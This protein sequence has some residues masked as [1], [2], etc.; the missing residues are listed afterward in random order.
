MKK[1]CRGIL[2]CGVL[3]LAIGLAGCGALP[4]LEAILIDF[5]L[6]PYVTNTFTFS[7]G[8]IA[9]DPNGVVTFKWNFGDGSMAQGQVVSYSYK[10]GGTYTVTLTVVTTDSSGNQR[11]LNFF[12]TVS[13]ISQIAFIEEDSF[14]DDQ[15]YIINADGTGLFQVT[16]TADLGVTDS[17]ELDMNGFGQI[18]YSCELPSPPPGADDDQICAVN[19][20]GTDNRVL[21]SRPHRADNPDIN[22]LGHIVYICEDGAGDP[23]LCT[24]DIN[25]GSRKILTSGVAEFD[26][27]INNLGQI[28]YT[29][30]DPS[31]F[32]PQVCVIDFDGSDQNQLTNN[33]IGFFDVE[34]NDLGV[35]TFE[36][37]DSGFDL[38]ICSIDYNGGSVSQITDSDCCTDFYNP[39]M[40]QF[41]KVAFGCDFFGVPPPPSAGSAPFQ[42]CVINSDGSGFRVTPDNVF[43]TDDHEY[44]GDKIA[45][46]CSDDFFFTVDLCVYNDS[47]TFFN[48]LIDDTIDLED[49]AIR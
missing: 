49:I 1:S 14:G 33:S 46:Y 36:C 37:L 34:I 25:G 20:D 42:R 10:A 17:D 22:D 21:T 7:A 12:T 2:S 11:H 35:V 38:E 43:D 32:T 27:E 39:E 30:I 28:A 48:K 18:V 6:G 4:G 29:C 31:F 45:S 13:V 3:L 8:A 40:N 41:G 47:A 19:A 26:A 16:Q 23:H 44:S 15:V 24:V 9:I 5:G